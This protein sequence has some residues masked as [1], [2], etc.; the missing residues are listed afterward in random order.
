MPESY[1]ITAEAIQAERKR[2]DDDLDSFDAANVIALDELELRP[3]GPRD[4]HLRILAVSVEHNV[5]HA[6]LADTVNI[7]KLRGG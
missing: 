1:V 5:D 2:V 7:T 3:V 6:V 4:V